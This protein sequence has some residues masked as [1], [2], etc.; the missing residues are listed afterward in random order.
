LVG[1]ARGL[2]I[3][4][5]KVKNYVQLEVDLALR[6]SKVGTFWPESLLETFGRAVS[7]L[8]GDSW[9]FLISYSFGSANRSVHRARINEEY[10]VAHPVPL[11]IR[12]SRRSMKVKMTDV[13][14]TIITSCCVSSL[15]TTSRMCMF[16][17]TF[18]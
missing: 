17:L 1:E 10:L 9:L 12:I 16:S 8:Q 15:L 18:F 4:A 5:H 2:W 11:T 7:G 3:V 13:V 14:L 6:Y